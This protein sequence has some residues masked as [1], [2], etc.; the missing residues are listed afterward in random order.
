MSRILDAIGRLLPARA[1]TPDQKA[2]ATGALIALETLGQ[3]AWA[4]RNYEAFAREGFMQ[5]AIV[6]RSV[7][8]IAEAAASVPLLAYDG[9]DELDAHPLLDLIARPSPDHTSTDFLEAWYGFLLVAGNAYV[10][11]VA[12]S[13][14]L[15][16]LYVLRPDRMKVI[17][18]P[19][20]WP[21]AFEY[22]ANGMTTRFAGEA[23]GSVRPI[24]HTRLFHP[25]NDHY[26][27]SPIEAAATAIDIHNETSAWNKAL[28][29]NSARPS[30]ALVYAAKNGNLTGEQ[31]K[32]LRAELEEAFQGARNA[33]RPMLLEGGLDWKPLSLSPKDM[34]F[35]A[36]K[37]AAARD[38]ALALG[39]PPML[40]GIPGDNTYTW[41]ARPYPAFPFD[42]DAWGDG[43]NWQRGHWLTGRFSSAPLAE[44]VAKLLGDFGFDAHSTASLNGTVPG[45]VIDRVMA[46]RDALEPLELAYFFDSLES[47]AQIVFR[48]RGSEPPALELEEGD[49]VE[50]RAGSALLTLTRGQETELPASA[51]LRFIASSGEYGQA[52]AEARRIAGAS[53]RVSEADLPLVL[54]SAQAE[55]IAE[56]LLFE[57]WAARERASFSLPPSC[58]AIEP[59]DVVRLAT[60]SPDVDSRLLRITEIG[61]HGDREVEARSVDPEIYDAGAGRER[62]GRTTIPVIAGQPLVEFVDL[63]LLR[64][65]EPPAAGYAAAIQSPWSGSVAIYGS[66]ET[67]GYVLKAMASVPATIGVTLSDLPPGPEGRLDYATRLTVEVEGEALTSC[68]TLQLLAGRNIAAVCNEAGEWEVL[69]F[70]AATLIATG[71]YELSGLL[72]G[73]GGTERA[74]RSPLAAGARFVLV[75][76]ALTRVDLAT[77]EIRLPYYWRFGPAARDIGDATFATETH[78]YEGLGLKPL[79][80]V[81]VRAERTAGDLTLS[82]LRRTRIGGD[83][84]ETPDV[85]LSEDWESYEI[86]ILDGESVQRTLSATSNSVVYTAAQQT[87]DFGA[88]QSAIAVRVYQLSGSYGRGTP[89]DATV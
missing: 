15:R 71:T 60:A 30:G 7:R 13:G 51:K 87:A 67:S 22:S 62:T 4:P 65:D 32:R 10:E 69:Q 27:M 44:T 26:G 9:D 31:F 88:P 29:D 59:A 50:T 78:T 73:Q 64:G 41:D 11:A 53:G 84:W 52:I 46:A 63:P 66:P 82:W 14:R 57:S 89:R 74:M 45:Y 20:G 48:H 8:M 86:E 39:V 18:G 35:I 54:D 61:E 80:P 3:P 40:L 76:S 5:N 2:S 16:E 6:Y 25:D 33:G 43:D 83:A 58:L 24:L 81:H 70:A 72:R 42:T 17:P 56:T 75:N 77:S 1:P 19:N 49:L 79:S 37:H 34:D 68:T 23:V 36:A 47:G 28:L 21:E 85:P 55:T 12:V 38:I